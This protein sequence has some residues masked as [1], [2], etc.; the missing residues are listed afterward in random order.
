MK[1]KKKLKKIKK[2]KSIEL[3]HQ[4]YDTSYETELTAYKTNKKKKYR[5][6]KRKKPKKKILLK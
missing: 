3:T 4:I 5:F 1:L 2:L 6:K